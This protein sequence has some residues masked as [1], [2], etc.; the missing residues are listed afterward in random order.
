M[1][2]RILNRRELR[3]QTDQAEQAEASSSEPS[4]AVVGAKPAARGKAAAPK[5]RKPRKT[6]APPRMRALWCLF[7]G[8]M[9]EVA[10]FD[11]NQRPAAEAKLAAMLGKQKGVYFLQIVKQPMPAAKAEAASSTG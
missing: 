1:A 6:K 8:G 7:D 11:Y 5:V 3:K 9:K 10:L 2:G 4:D